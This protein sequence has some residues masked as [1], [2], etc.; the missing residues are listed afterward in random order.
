MSYAWHHVDTRF[1]PMLAVVDGDDALCLLHIGPDFAAHIPAG[2]QQSPNR[3]GKVIGQLSEYCQGN[4][5]QFDLSLAPIGTPFQQVAWQALCAIPYGETRSYGE[6]A[7]ALGKPAA[8][9]AAGRANGANPIALIVPCH[10]VIGSN[11]ALTGYAGGL[12]L[13]R[14]LLDFE[15]QHAGFASLPLFQ[16]SAAAAPTDRNLPIPMAPRKIPD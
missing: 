12:P 14:A 11:G 16:V 6:Q 4:R 5:R 13:K 3:L 9:R 10:R 7:R 1:G 15:R 8:V 2:A